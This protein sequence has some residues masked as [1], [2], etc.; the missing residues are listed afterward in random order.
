[1][2]TCPVCNNSKELC[3]VCKCKDDSFGFNDWLNESITDM[4][5]SEFIIVLIILLLLFS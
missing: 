5:K 4:N 2:Y 1:M 3:P